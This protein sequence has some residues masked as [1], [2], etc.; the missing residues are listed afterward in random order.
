MYRI[1]Y[2]LSQLTYHMIYIC[3]SHCL[4]E[5]YMQGKYTTTP[6]L[7]LIPLHPHFPQV[8]TA[9]LFL[10]VSPAVTASP[11]GKNLASSGAAVICGG[12]P[13]VIKKL[14]VHLRISD[15]WNELGCVQLNCL[16]L[17]YMYF[18]ILMLISVLNLINE[19]TPVWQSLLPFFVFVE[20]KQRWH[21]T[22]LHLSLYCMCVCTVITNVFVHV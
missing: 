12:T 16:L 7:K 1:L 22:T 20:W 5:W 14:T 18:F 4:T 8:L 2:F 9:V 10:W 13:L 11:Y 21:Q 19:K 3:T 17:C 6:V 15:F